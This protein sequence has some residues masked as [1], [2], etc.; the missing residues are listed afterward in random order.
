M[1]E[2]LLARHGLLKAVR[3]FFYTGGYVEVETPNLMRTAPPDP[4]IEPLKVFA[5]GKGPFQLH[6]S[7]EMGMKKLLPFCERIFQVCKTYRV[8]ELDEV[9]NTEF[10]MLEWYMPGTYEDAIGELEH[11]VSYLIDQLKVEGSQ[12]L[13]GPWVSRTLEEIFVERTGVSPLGMDRATLQEVL[14]EK[15]LRISGREGWED[16]FFMFYVQEV[17][18]WL[19]DVDTLVVR[20]WPVWLSSMAKKK[21]DSRVERFEFYVRGLE[22]ANGYTELLDPEEQRERFVTDNKKRMFQGKQ[23]FALDL[24]LLDALPAIN[25]PV[26][27]VSVGLDRLLMALLQVERIEEV[28]PFRIKI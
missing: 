3:E 23:V 9:H 10:T 26:A 13:K 14:R 25:G 16:L 20:D 22:L 28:L 19:H 21:D 27:G 11:L 4:F 5:G 12:Y 1:K 8:E 7:P 24:E 6:T 17:E 18:P 2:I 15:G